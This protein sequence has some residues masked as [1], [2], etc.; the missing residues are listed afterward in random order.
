MNMTKSFLIIISL[1]LI[2]SCDQ[3]TWITELPPDLEGGIYELS[4]K[5]TV[6]I[7]HNGI[8]TFRVNARYHISLDDIVAI[9]YELEE[10]GTYGM[11]VQTVPGAVDRISALTR[12]NIGKP[13]VFA[14]NNIVYLAPTVTQEIN[15]NSIYLNFRDDHLSADFLSAL[16][17]EQNPAFDKYNHDAYNEA[18]EVLST[19]TS[20][21]IQNN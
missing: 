8:D 13:L 4:V 19:D 21:V 3:A 7:D 18:L 15:E 5:G 6:M 16:H 9:S 17:G 20:G 2:S 10:P 14:L 1:S 11:M 12:R